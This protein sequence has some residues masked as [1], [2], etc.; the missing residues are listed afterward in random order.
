MSRATKTR[1][2][3]FLG[4]L[5]CASSSLA[6]QGQLAEEVSVPEPTELHTVASADGSE[7]VWSEFLG[8]IKSA[9]ASATLTAIEIEGPDGEQVR[10]V[11][12]T[13]ANAASTDQ[14][15]VTDGL[16]ANL[17][18][19]LQELEF[20]RQ[21]NSECEAKYRCVHGIARCRPS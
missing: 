2:L 14:I 6:V 20:T 19:E 17:R 9:D 8:E 18:N 7:V 15:Y 4:S 16:L 1:L 5:T 3:V 12:I 13:L 11:L 10:G 21:F